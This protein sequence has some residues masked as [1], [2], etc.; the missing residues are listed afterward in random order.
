MFSLLKNKSK[1]IIYLFLFLI[2]FSIVYTSTLNPF[3]SRIMNVDTSVYISITQGITRGHVLYKNLADNKGPLLYFLSVPGF[4]LG[5]TAGVWITEL[6]FIFISFFFMYK[7]ALLFTNTKTALLTVFFT[8]LATHPF[9][10][11]NAGTEE[12]ALPF[13]AVSFYIF[14]KYYISTKKTT[15][16]EIVT[17]GLSFTCSI[18]IRLNIFPLWGGFCLII[19]VESIIKKKYIDIFKYIIGF[20]FGILIVLIPIYF[21]LKINNAIGDFLNY[22]ILGGITRGFRAS[23]KDFVN[24]FYIVINRN[25]SFIPLCLSIVWLFTKYKNINTFYFYSYIVSY[26][27][28]VI[29]LSFSPGNSHYNLIL[30][31]FFVPAVI[32]VSETLLEAFSKIKY[33]YM[34]L[35]L[36]FCITFSEGIIRL[37]YYLFFNFDSNVSL[38]LAGKIIDDNTNEYDKIINLGWNG[39]IYPFTQRDAASKYIYQGSGLD[40]ITGA[41]E[42][43][44]SDILTNKPAI[45]TLF[46]GEDAGEQIINDWHTPIFKMID[47]EYHLLSD[48]NEFVLYIRNN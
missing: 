48:E 4:Y 1:I 47:N 29:F 34:V 44:L 45:I 17:L 11:V 38:K 15:F 6:I 8:S 2:A 7:T 33:K 25:F 24:I 23:L 5:G 46:I 16:F 21:Y 42:E 41:K 10:Y 36:F 30:I 12:Y 37:S 20:I 32:F 28:S 22:V 26:L 14:T 35:V 39:Y 31:P 3:L 19:I 27:L 13:L 18:M 40:Q 43:F 9:Y